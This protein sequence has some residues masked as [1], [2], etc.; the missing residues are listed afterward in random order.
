MN[1]ICVKNTGHMSIAGVYRCVYI[2]LYWMEIDF[3]NFKYFWFSRLFS[4]MDLFPRLKQVKHIVLSRYRRDNA[5]EFDQKERFSVWARAAEFSAGNSKGLSRKREIESGEA[6]EIALDF[7]SNGA[8][9]RL[10]K[11]DLGNRFHP[12]KSRASGNCFIPLTL[13][14]RSYY[15]LF[16][17][18]NKFEIYYQL[19]LLL[20]SLDK[21]TN[22]TVTRG[23]VHCI[24]D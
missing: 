13:F 10:S 1:Y 15:F 5:T 7:F 3:V 21:L 9:P 18:L 11:C 23:F 24:G 4:E 16:M 20:F 14:I 12:S 6:E 19:S 2:C 17:E 22:I 8:L